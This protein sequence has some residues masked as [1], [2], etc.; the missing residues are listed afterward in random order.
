[1][2]ATIQITISNQTTGIAAHNKPA[3]LKRMRVFPNPS[4]DYVQLHGELEFPSVIGIYNL[5]G[6]LIKEERLE[7]REQ[8][9]DVSGLQEGLFIVRMRGKNSNQTAG[10]IKK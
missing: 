8:Q 1:V 10:F 7:T 5:T 4:S 2:K 3:E 9:I 6:R